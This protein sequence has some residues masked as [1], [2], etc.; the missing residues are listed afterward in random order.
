[1]PKWLQHF[2]D[3]KGTI[4]DYDKYK[5]YALFVPL[6]EVNGEYHLLFEVRSK[7]VK[8]P[9]EICFPGGK[10]DKTDRSNE[11]AAIRELCEELGVKEEQVTIIGELDYII[12]HGNRFIYPFLGIIDSR[13][14]FH[15]NK[16]EV[17]EIFTVP[18]SALR[19]MTPQKHH[20][21]L[22][23]RPNKDFPYHLIPHGKNYPWAKPMI[24]ELFYEYD[25]K[26]I[27]G[28]TARVLNHFLDELKKVDG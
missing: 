3:R 9:G 15:I 20:V 25:E 22:E 26:I 4:L 1:M 8:Q 19:N 17:E 12:S 16:V 13:A 28:L 2:K 6:I 23:V 5:H 7:H 27:W 24:T 21:A 10:I 18:L 11:A 14:T